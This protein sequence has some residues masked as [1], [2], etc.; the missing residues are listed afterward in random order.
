MTPEDLTP[1]RQAKHLTWRQLTVFAP[2]QGDDG[3]LLTD[4]GESLPLDTALPNERVPPASG[5]RINALHPDGVGIAVCDPTCLQDV[6]QAITQWCREFLGR[7][8]IKF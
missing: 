1:F 3:S 4:R 8:D 5:T 2:H 7:D 6:R